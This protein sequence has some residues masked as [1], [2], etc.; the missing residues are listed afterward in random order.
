[1]G[2]NYNSPFWKPEQ[3]Q[4]SLAPRTI[5]DISFT[6]DCTMCEHGSGVGK[7]IRDDIFSRS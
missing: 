6:V 1:M 5:V 7:V 4:E 2:L 3:E